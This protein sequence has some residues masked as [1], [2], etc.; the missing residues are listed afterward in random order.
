[1][2]LGMVNGVGRGM[3]VLDVNPHASRGREDFFGG[4]VVDNG[5]LV[6]DLPVRRRQRNALGSCEKT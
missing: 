3:G 2:P 6:E 1:M 5:L 4:R